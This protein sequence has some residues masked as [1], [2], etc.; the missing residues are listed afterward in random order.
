MR[1]VV[2]LLISAFLSSSLVGANSGGTAKGTSLFFSF[3]DGM[4]EWT[5]GGTDL[6]L[7]WSITRSQDI[8]K[9]GN[10]SLKLF[11]ANFND[12]GKI[13]IERAFVVEP[14]QTYQVNVK[15]SFASNDYG[16]INSTKMFTAVL[17]RSPKTRQD[18]IPAYQDFTGAGDS[19]SGYKWLKKK[20]EFN[21]LSRDEGML[22]IIVGIWGVFER[23]YTYYVDQVQVT[24]T[25][26]AKEELP[27]ISSVTFDGAKKLLI[28]GH[29]F[30]TS[31]RVVI[32]SVDVSSHIRASSD[33]LIKLKGKALSLNLGN[34]GFSNSSNTVLVIDDATG[35][36]SNVFILVL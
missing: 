9:D 11:L 2:C 33:S 32:N 4:E 25:K 19:G 7:E 35:T 23:P 31:P 22:H 21:V 6:P 15:Y 20:H 12:A 34:L 5:A 29:R 30:G 3:E 14:G 17:E 1:W 18:L 10:T 28:Q 36:V 8:A 27:L 24:L 26:T 13:W 16:L